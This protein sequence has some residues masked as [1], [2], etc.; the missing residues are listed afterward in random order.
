MSNE[1]GPGRGDRENRGLSGMNLFAIVVL[2]LLAGLLAVVVTKRL[3]Y[4]S[5]EHSDLV[6]LINVSKYDSLGGEPVKDLPGYI[7]IRDERGQTSRY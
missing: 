7:D 5:I 3:Y 4:V 6:R 1:N 2:V